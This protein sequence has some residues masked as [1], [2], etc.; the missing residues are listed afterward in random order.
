MT[1]IGGIV[2]ISCTGYVCRKFFSGTTE[3]DGFEML[4]VDGEDG[5][6]MLPVDGEAFEDDPPGV[7]SQH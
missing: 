7:N 1:L 2:F 3:A 5:F 6:E 4:P